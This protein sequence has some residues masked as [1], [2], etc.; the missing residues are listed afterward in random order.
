[1]SEEEKLPQGELPPEET[2][3]REHVYASPLK[4]IWAWVGVVYMVIIVLLITYLFATAKLLQGI[5]GLMVLA[6]ILLIAVDG[7]RK[8]KAAQPPEKKSAPV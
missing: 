6:S 4:R 1:M 3:P 2:P 8:A 5:G 7:N